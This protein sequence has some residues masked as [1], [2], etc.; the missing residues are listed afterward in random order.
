MPHRKGEWPWGQLPS[1]PCSHSAQN[2]GSCTA[3]GAQSMMSNWG[4]ICR[5]F[6]SILQF[7]S[8]LLGC[9]STAAS[10]NSR[11]YSGKYCDPS[12]GMAVQASF[13]NR[14]S[15]RC[16][17]SLL[18]LSVRPESFGKS[19]GLGSDGLL[20]I[21]NICRGRQGLG[22]LL[23]FSLYESFTLHLKNKSIIHYFR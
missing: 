4:W 21:M 22:F 13:K 8:A 10:K 1:C 3:P 19:Q 7:P 9:S 12:L 2:S 16:A 6:R 5:V 20:G 14:T 18:S 15:I 17:S 23:S 11:G